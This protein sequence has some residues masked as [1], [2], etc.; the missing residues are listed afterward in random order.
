MPLTIVIVMISKNTIRF[1]VIAL[2]PSV[3]VTIQETKDS[4][5]TKILR[6]NLNLFFTSTILVKSVSKVSRMMINIKIERG[7]SSNL[8]ASVKK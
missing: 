5:I 3:R 1:G 6:L 8:L 2:F 7:Y 4:E